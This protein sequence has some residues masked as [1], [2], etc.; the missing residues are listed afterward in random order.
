ML[1]ECKVFSVKDIN[2]FYTIRTLFS[3]ATFAMRF[4]HKLRGYPFGKSVALVDAHNSIRMIV[5]N[6]AIRT[7]IIFWVNRN[8]S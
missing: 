2:Y 8:R 4:F 3:I 1:Y 5:Y 7:R 6:H